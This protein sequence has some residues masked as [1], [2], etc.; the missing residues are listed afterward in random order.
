MMVLAVM[1]AKGQ[2]KIEQKINL[3]M[4]LCVANKIM[5]N[6]LSICLEFKAPNA[7]ESR[8]DLKDLIKGRIKGSN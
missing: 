4:K 3:S 5:T 2:F 8:L 6:A 1:M 7:M